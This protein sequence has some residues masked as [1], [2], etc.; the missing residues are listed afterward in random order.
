MEKICMYIGRIALACIVTD[1]IIGV[2]QLTVKG[3]K[4]IYQMHIENKVRKEAAQLSQRAED[5]VA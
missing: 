5:V 3:C 1:A 4:A 2:A